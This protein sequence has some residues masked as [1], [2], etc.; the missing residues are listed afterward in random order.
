MI[1]KEKCPKCDHPEMKY[2]CIQTRSADE[3]STVFY[4][5]EKCGY[6]YSAN[7]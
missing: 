4:E 1:I 7:N 2:H 6:T 5:C 3:G